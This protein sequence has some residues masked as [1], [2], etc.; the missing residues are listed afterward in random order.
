MIS[1]FQFL[2]NGLAV[3]HTEGNGWLRDM[4]WG[5]IPE[6]KAREESG[7]SG[8]IR[9]SWR[10]LCRQNSRQP[11]KPLLQRSPRQP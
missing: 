1:F 8:W 2:A 9:H 7:P 10:T 6:G 3:V 4:N 11:L 5:G